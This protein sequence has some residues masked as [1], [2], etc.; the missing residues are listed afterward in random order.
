LLQAKWRKGTYS[1]GTVSKAVTTDVI[2]GTGVSWLANIGADNSPPLTW[3]QATG[4]INFAG[5]PA[6][7]NTITFNSILITFV[8]GSPG[9]NQVQIGGSLTATITNL[10]NALN[11]HGDSHISAA[12]YANVGGTQLSITHDAPGTGGNSYTLAKSGANMT[13]SGANLTGGVSGY[14]A[15]EIQ[16]SS[17][18]SNWFPIVKLDG[19]SQLRIHNAGGYTPLIAPS[20]SG[21]SYAIRANYH[22]VMMRL[23]NYTIRTTEFRNTA[24][25]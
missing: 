14:A 18:D 19:R 23:V 5:Q 3:Y 9:A 10:A 21:A 24:V 22:A 11:A 20:L 4:Y 1:A 8:A 16:V 15:W 12:T 17:I 7:G 13:L 6:A 2:T 25:T